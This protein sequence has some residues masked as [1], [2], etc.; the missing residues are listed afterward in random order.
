VPATPIDL[1]DVDSFDPELNA[2]LDANADRVRAYLTEQAAIDHEYDTNPR[3]MMRRANPHW[4]AYQHLDR[5]LDAALRGRP[6]RAWHYTRLT[7]DEVGAIRAGGLGLSTRAALDA[8]LADRIA[9][10]DLT[11]PQAQ[12]IRAAS[13][14][15]GDQHDAR[16]GQVCA[17]AY[18]APVA[19]PGV[20]RLLRYWGGEVASFHLEDPDLLFRLGEIGRP[21]V[22]EVAAPLAAVRPG[23]AL[24]KAA[25]AAFAHGAGIAF[26]AFMPDLF[27]IEPLAPTAVLAIHSDGEEAFVSLGRGFP[28]D[29]A[30]AYLARL[31]DPD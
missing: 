30:G 14:L 10:G 11:A 5:L 24:G 8:R 22:L 9:A 1:W 31:I 25:I 15:H 21:R 19:D 12:A 6:A 13:P 28:R 7:D 16:A 2:I 26:E 29:P 18:P 17:C 3:L 4:D 27:F 20:E 23:T